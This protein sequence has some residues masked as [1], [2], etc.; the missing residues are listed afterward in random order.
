MKAY[1]KA[2]KLVTLYQCLS[3]SKAERSWEGTNLSQDDWR[4]FS[5]SDIWKAFL[6]ELSDREAYILQL[7]K[8]ADKEWS[9]DVLRG[10]L[11]EIDFIKQIPALILLSIKDK[12]NRKEIEN[13]EHDG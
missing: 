5:E 1:F 6:L 3:L 4:K 12:E 13:A 7:F 8:D 2:R 9:P 11:T 10:K